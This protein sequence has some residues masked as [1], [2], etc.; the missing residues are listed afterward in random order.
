MHF[1]YWPAS[2]VQ[3]GSYDTKK[4]QHLALV[5][6]GVDQ[7][8]TSYNNGF[9]VVTDSVTSTDFQLQ[10]VPLI[11]GNN[12]QHDL[13]QSPGVNGEIDGVRLMAHARSHRNVCKSAFGSSCSGAIAYHPTST[14]YEIS[15]QIKDIFFLFSFEYTLYAFAIVCPPP[16]C[17]YCNFFESIFDLA[18]LSDSHFGVFARSVLL[19]ACTHWLVPRLCTGF[20]PTSMPCEAKLWAKLS[21]VC[22]WMF[23]FFFFALSFCHSW[24]IWDFSTCNISYITNIL[25]HLS[26]FPHLYP[27][28]FPEL[29]LPQ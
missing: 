5:F 21:V 3:G 4:W 10:A 12:R 1:G 28:H 15:M 14:Q 26:C 11:I 29:P 23:F 16:K 25:N 2:E 22:Y 20:V 27:S 13:Q 6:D 8:V 7:T 17:T 9:E 24:H 19:P 18:S